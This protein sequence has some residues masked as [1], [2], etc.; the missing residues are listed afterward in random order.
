MQ[1]FENPV[2]NNELGL[3]DLYDDP[4]ILRKMKRALEEQRRLDEEAAE[5][6]SSDVEDE[7]EPRPVKREARSKSHKRKVEEI[8]DE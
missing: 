7:D 2:S 4:V 3:D 6:S 5:E 8:D 1:L